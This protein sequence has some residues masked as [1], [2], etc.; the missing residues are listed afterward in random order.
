MSDSGAA[1]VPAPSRPG[2]LA[3]CAGVLVSPRRT[4]VGVAARP[5]WVGV[6]LL[7][8]LI[9]TL[10]AGGFRLTAVGRQAT[11]DQQVRTVESFGRHLTDAQYGT[12]QR[13]DRYAAPMAAAQGLVGTPLS[14]FVVAVLLYAFFNARAGRRA[15]FV[16]VFAVVAH[17]GVVLAVQQLV[18]LPLDYVRQTLASP[19]N[20]SAVIPVFD[21]GSFLAGLTGSLDL[22]RLWW[23]VVVALGLGAVY[24][25]RSGPIVLGLCGV[26]LAIGV[27]LAAIQVATGGV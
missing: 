24:R 17:A 20:L 2:L 12:L 23:I 8:S 25:R 18:V 22:F 14:V 26:Y 3:R 7:T 27:V 19:A 13:L 15:R 5:D 11:L 10:C 16:E 1:T 4:L 21:Q 9:A 6:L